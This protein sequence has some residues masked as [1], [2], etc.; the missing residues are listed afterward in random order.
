MKMVYL[1]TFDRDMQHLFSYRPVLHHYVV[2]ILR[3][4]GIKD[5][6]L[7]LFYYLKQSF[8]NALRGVS[9][10]AS[11]ITIIEQLQ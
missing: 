4:S 6:I 11:F 10:E 8:A 7:C 1:A 2:I 5:C 3:F 9:G